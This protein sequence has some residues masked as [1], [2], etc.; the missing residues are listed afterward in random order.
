MKIHV[1][2]FFRAYPRHMIYRIS[3]QVHPW[4]LITSQP[5]QS[6]HETV[7]DKSKLIR[8]LR[9]Q[10]GYLRLKFFLKSNRFDSKYPNWL[11]FKVINA[12][13]SSKWLW[14]VRAFQA[15]L[16]RVYLIRCLP[17]DEPKS[18]MYLTNRRNDQITCKWS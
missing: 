13:L 11:P 10:F 2:H 16:V 1:G 12:T 15:P 7:T 9:D 5:V 18:E 17:A 3:K 4:S 8:R 14:L 6:N